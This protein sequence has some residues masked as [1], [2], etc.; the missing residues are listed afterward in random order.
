MSK[1]GGQSWQEVSC[2]VSAKEGIKALRLIAVG[3][4][5][6]SRVY[7]SIGFM[8]PG[9]ASGWTFCRSNDYGKTFTILSNGVVNQVVE[10]RSNPNL[11]IGMT[12][13]KPE[14]T[15]SKDGGIHWTN[16]GGGVVVEPII[17]EFG[18]PKVFRTW[19]EN[20]IFGWFDIS[21]VHPVIQIET[22]PLDENTFYCLTYKGIYVTRDLG[23]TFRLLPLAIEYMHGVN[24]FAVDPVDGR[25]IYA[26][27]KQSDLYRSTDRGCTWNRLELPKF[28]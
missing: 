10:S 11:L 18:Y 2:S 20:K 5:S 3:Q 24:S 19:K 27:V 9:W 25:F 7:A 28:Q 8:G 13:D 16:I 6:E 21:V 22:D 15:M 23:K 12:G 26:T 17:E 1:D 4:H 14:I